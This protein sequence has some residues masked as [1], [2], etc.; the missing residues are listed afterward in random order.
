MVYS[1]DVLK[2]KSILIVDDN[3]I[4]LEVIAETLEAC[5]ITIYIAKNGITGVQRAQ[6]LLP[7]LILLDIMMDDLNGFMVCDTLKS[8]PLTHNIPIILITALADHESKIKGFKCGAIDYLTKPIDKD[9]VIARISNH[10]YV[11]HLHSTLEEKVKERTRELE[12]SNEL[13]HEIINRHILTERELEAH[14]THLEQRV[15]ER[16]DQLELLH[17]KLLVQARKAGMCEVAV[18]TLHNVGNLLNSVGT[19]AQIVKGAVSKTDLHH[20]YTN[21]TEHLKNETSKLYQLL[22][23]NEIGNKFVKYIEFL[24]SETIELLE[25]VDNYMYRIVVHV[26]KI[27]TVI[28]DQRKHLGTTIVENVNLPEII[29]ESVEKISDDLQDSLISIK[30]DL[31]PISLHLQKG[32]LETVL[33]NVLKNAITSLSY[34]VKE[35]K[36]ISVKT[37]LLGGKI[38]IIIEDNG[39]G[40]D[41]NLSDN[42]FVSGYT[43]WT[44]HY[45]FGLHTAANYVTELNGHIE[46]ESDGVGKGVK[47]TITLL[48]K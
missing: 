24:L 14:K 34:S 23:S 43:T 40:I 31:E 41:P 22:H 45:G 5:S 36:Y 25:T 29:N 11:K 32:K 3:P 18:N 20:K 30:M 4:N 17:K 38:K 12:Q 33:D 48:K 1:Q 47:V 10:L 2:G 6:K 39:I 42:V 7:D 15:Q 21:L 28:S 9:E 26:N 13:L 37:Q 19:S 16:T 44:G 8:D 35:S 46:F 27:D